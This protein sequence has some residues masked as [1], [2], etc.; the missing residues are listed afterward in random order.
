M[1]LWRGIEYFGVGLPFGMLIGLLVYLTVV[2][3]SG[4]Y[5]PPDT[6]A[7]KSR[8]LLLI[9]LIAAIVSHYVEIN[10]GIAIVSTRTYFWV[11]SALLVLLGYLLPGFVEPDHPD[12]ITTSEDSTVEA[13]GKQKSTGG[14]RKKHRGRETFQLAENHPLVEYQ[15]ALI[16]ALII[17]IVMVTLVFD[18]ISNSRGSTSIPEIIWASLT[19]LPNRNYAFSPGLLFMFLTTWLFMSIV[20]GV[21]YVDR[22]LKSWWKGMGI[23]LFGSLILFALYAIG[24]AS[25]LATIATQSAN[26]LDSVLKQVG[27]FEGLLTRFY[28]AASI[29]VLILAALLPERKGVHL[30]SA[31]LAGIL[32]APTL[33]VLVVFF[34]FFS[35]L[36]IIQADIAYKIAE[37]FSR[38][39]QWPVAITIYNRANQLAPN[40]DYY[41]LFLGRAYL[42]HA[43][44][45]EDIVQR[46]RFIQDAESELLKAQALNPLNTDH[47]ANLARLYSLWASFTNEP[48]VRQERGEIS[49]NYFSKALKLSRNSALLWDEWAYL[50]VTVL[51]QPDAAYEKISTAIEID[52]KYHRSYALM[53]E[54]YLRRS[55]VAEGSEKQGFL[56]Q[57]AGSF[58]KA[59]EMPTPGEPAAKFNYAQMLASIYVQLGQYPPAIDA[60]LK[61]IEV[62][63]QGT[64]TWRIREA[65]AGLYVRTGD[66]A[67]ALLHLQ[68]ALNE[69]PDEEKVRL[70]ALLAQLQQAGEP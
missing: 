47:T 70:S 9:V 5:K 19:R 34:A 21:E 59:L 37:P 68:Y 29:L 52:P 49:S 44:T 26:S 8:Y 1:I 48:Q 67:N 56:E 15:D 30:G 40:E 12:S 53:G 32:L 62:A 23:I 33:F 31:R 36:R 61:A 13:A 64:E 41:Y 16:S 43:K 58:S 66:T 17:S 69:A 38:S 6:Q 3:I 45:F 46:D 51:Q 55:M 2:A 11:Y 7:E 35:N 20:M 60:Y 63:P 24:H 14:T 57:A 54:Y 22:S 65:L 10:F 39:G 42:E 25:A 27:R 28:L 18:F 50:L 4:N